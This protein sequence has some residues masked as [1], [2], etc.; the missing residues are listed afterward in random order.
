ME[1]EQVLHTKEGTGKASYANNSKFQVPR[2]LE[3]E[4]GV[5]LNKGNL[6]IGKACPPEVHKAY[7]DQF[8]KDFT[9]FLSLHSQEL[10][11]GGRMV[12]T[13]PGNVDSKEPSTL[14]MLFSMAL[15]DMVLQVWSGNLRF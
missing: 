6:N 8:E 12:L 14:W 11:L 1:V 4:D 2:G 15:N 9:L 13:M 7:H 3:G 10:V 5:A